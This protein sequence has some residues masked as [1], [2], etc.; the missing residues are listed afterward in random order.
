MH[1]NDERLYAM[2]NLIGGIER[3]QAAPDDVMEAAQ[4]SREHPGRSGDAAIAEVE[5]FP[6]HPAVKALVAY[7]DLLARMAESPQWTFD[8]GNAPRQD[9]PSRDGLAQFIRVIAEAD[10]R[11]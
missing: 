4:W 5:P 2:V 10:A 8:L 7:P 6:W 9:G 1:R 3:S 11:D